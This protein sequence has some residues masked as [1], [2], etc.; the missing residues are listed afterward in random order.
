MATPGP[1]RKGAPPGIIW[2]EVAQELLTTGRQLGASN[3]SVFKQK[4]VI[5]RAGEIRKPPLPGNRQEN[6]TPSVRTGYSLWMEGIAKGIPPEVMDK[7]PTTNLKTLIKHWDKIKEHKSPPRG[8]PPQ[9]SNTVVPSAS[10]ETS[11]T[12]PKSGNGTPNI[13]SVE[14]RSGDLKDETSESL[15]ESA[16]RKVGLLLMGIELLHKTGLDYRN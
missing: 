10:P 8:N 9:K 3:T 4:T 6:V 16:E 5:R 15:F 14:A 12:I 7:S 2:L 1:R 11:L 13:S